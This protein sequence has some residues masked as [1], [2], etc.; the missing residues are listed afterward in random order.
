MSSKKPARSVLLR[1]P[2]LSMSGYGV[3]A[4]QIARWLFDK[5]D[6]APLDRQIEISTQLLNWG[7]T[8]WLVDT[9][10]CDGLVGR[11]L[12]ASSLPKSLYDVTIQIQLPNEWCPELGKFNVG[13][14]AG[15]EADAC[16]PAWVEC[17]NK[18]NLVVVLSEFTRKSL[19]NSGLVT[20]PILVVP[21]SFPDVF[22]TEE[23]S[24]LD[25]ELETSFNFLVFG[26][27]TGTRPE[28]DRKNI[29]YTL[30]WLME[31][32]ENDKDVGIILKTNSGRFSKVD[33]YQ[34]NIFSESLL[35]TINKAANPKFY[36]LHGEMSDKELV[37][38]YTHPKIK[39]LVTLTHGEGFG[40]PILEAAVCALPVIA[41]DW[42]AHTE[43][44]G[45]GRH[46]KIE[47]PLVTIPE[48]R[49]DNQ[50]WMSG[51]KWANP[52]EQDF[53]KQARKFYKASHMP[54][55]WAIDLK[56]KIDEKYCFASISKQYST[57]FENII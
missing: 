44:L 33:K 13:V 49:A 37:G 29:P 55:Q 39:A 50:I 22:L 16:N 52:N 18:M 45:L 5:A 14:T 9:D 48:T 1:G 19:I 26:Q 51:T 10:A 15:V 21:C 42:S 12:Q 23:P 2:T 28:D 25:L 20:T 38:L 40:L 4:R 27:I 32:F 7:S 8:P 36:L 17:V 57:I 47:A 11:L 46:I 43:F 35:Q 54:K 24:K 34:C 31:E 56:K 41:T 53:K 3:Y 30:K 6:N